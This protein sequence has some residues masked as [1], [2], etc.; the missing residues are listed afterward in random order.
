MSQT[1]NLLTTKFAK[2]GTTRYNQINCKR[3]A[4]IAL[5]RCNMMYQ[6]SGIPWMSCPT[7]QTILPWHFWSSS[8]PEPSWSPTTLAWSPGA[9]CES[10]TCQSNWFHHTP[11]MALVY[12]APL[13][14]TVSDIPGNVQRWNVCSDGS[15]VKILVPWFSRGLRQ[16]LIDLHC[17]PAYPLILKFP[18]P[19]M[20]WPPPRGGV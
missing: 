12:L 11:S 1:I 3:F 16:V 5:P 10:S 14:D 9:H 18:M 17:K 15:T 13:G 2:I 6:I 7:Q 4:E 19:W 20:C 8:P